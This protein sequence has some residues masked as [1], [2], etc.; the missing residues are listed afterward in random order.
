MCAILYVI[1]RVF[2][3]PAPA[4]IN[5]APSIAVTA[6]YCSG[7]NSSFNVTKSIAIGQ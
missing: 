4:I 6:L 3:E 1:T 5:I 7:F 2:P